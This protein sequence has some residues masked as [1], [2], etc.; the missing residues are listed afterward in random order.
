[1][2][3]EICQGLLPARLFLYLNPA[4]NITRSRVEI[5]RFLG[6]LAGIVAGKIKRLRVYFL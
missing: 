5:D 1:L 3:L 4:N 6:W 2:G